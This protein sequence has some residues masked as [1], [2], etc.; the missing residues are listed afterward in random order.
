M[1]ST[2]GVLESA[3]S[4][5]NTAQLGLN[6]TS[7]NIAN[8]DTEGYTRQA[9]N[10]SAKSPD[11]GSYRY[12][13]PNRV[14]QGVSVDSVYQIRNNFLDVRYR[15]ENSVYNLYETM[16]SLMSPIEQK[17]NEI[18]D[19]TTTTNKL[20]GLSG[21]IDNIITS[22]QKGQTSPT[23]PNI[24]QD[25]MTQV[26]LLASTIRD[27]AN[28]L[29]DALESA[30]RELSIYV[31][32]GIGDTSKGDIT[33]GGVNGIILDIQTLN[34]EIV[35]YEVTGQKANDLRDKRNLLLD[36][37]SSYINIDTVELENGMVT[38]KLQNDS[39]GY[40]I[41]DADN[42]ATTFNIATD[43]TSNQLVLQWGDTVDGD[44]NVIASSPEVT[45]VISSGIVKAYLNVI[46]G[47]GTGIDD[48][49]TGKCGN[50]GIPYLMK[51]LNE[52]AVAFLNIMNNADN[53]VNSTDVAGYQFLTY[54]G[55]SAGKTTADMLNDDVAST[56]GISDEWR[57]DGELFLK[58]YTGASPA[59]YYSN[60]EIALKK[61]TNTVPIPDST[62]PTKTYSNSFRDFADSF[63]SE[64]AGS[65]NSYNLKAESAKVNADNLNDQRL[66][67][68]SVSINDE[69][70]N[71]IKYQQAY[72]ANARVITV[73]DE[74]LDKLINSTG[75]I[76]R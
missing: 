45:A 73:I 40:S 10:I 49:A 54:S 61:T 68:T 28:S 50:I 23:D 63:T 57:M 65:V 11:T 3:R 19:S 14:G 48:L 46:N 7:Q 21:M 55:Y 20:I 69:G 17:F 34:H 33:S 74:M 44:G 26:D 6:V 70:V 71:I 43:A 36:K 41:I 56:I 47:D 24:S 35:S 76:G 12:A 60:Y 64:I 9:L 25:I 15:Y 27:D 29:K 39:S 2:F 16:K 38:I 75:V 31:Y 37:L 18:G 42:N 13:N 66:S 4:G 52:F 32:G 62:D 53:V 67:I 1:A 22:L 30:M 72:S 8:A 58:N 5:L 51:K 59:T